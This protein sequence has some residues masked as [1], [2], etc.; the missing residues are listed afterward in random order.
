MPQVV[1]AY[2][3]KVMPTNNF[4]ERVSKVIGAEELP[5]FVNE[6]VVRILLVVVYAEIFLIL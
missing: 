2:T 4:L 3:F 5:D 1:Q 6:Y